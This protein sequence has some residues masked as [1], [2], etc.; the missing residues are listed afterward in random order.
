MA[1]ILGQSVDA[2]QIFAAKESSLFCKR[3]MDVC[4]AAVLLLL[5]APVIVLFACIIRLSDGG[6]A[7]HRRRVVGLRGNFD[8]FKLRTMRMDADELLQ[9]DLDF[10]RRFSVNFKLRHDPRV[11]T[12]GRVIRR[13]GIDELPQL[14]NVLRGQM[15]LVGPRMISPAELSKFEGAAWIFNV[16]KPGLTGEW[17]TERSAEGG[18]AERVQ[19]ELQYVRNWSISGDLRILLKTPLRVLQGRG[20]S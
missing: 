6:P 16:V 11:T 1:G 8:A 12:I 19:M 14:W 3:V 4:G 9:R 20:A 17:Q 10:K 18:Y 5:A 2:P 13:Y 15:S 7:F